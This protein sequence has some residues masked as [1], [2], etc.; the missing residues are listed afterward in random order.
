MI[1]NQLIG[2]CDPDDI[3]GEEAFTV[4]VSWTDALTGIV[5]DATVTL[6]LAD[7]L[8]AEAP[9]LAKGNALVGYAET[10][11]DLHELRYG[12]HGAE[13]TTLCD[14]QSA[15][16]EAAPQD[17][18]I[19]AS[20]LLMASYCNTVRLGE[21]HEGSCDGDPEA[22]FAEALGVCD[23]EV[24]P[25]PKDLG[26][27]S[28][29]VRWG[30]FSRLY[31]SSQIVPREGYRFAALSTG[32][33]GEDLTIP[34]LSGSS[35]FADPQPEYSGEVQ[36]TPSAQRVYDLTTVSITLTAP[37]DAHSFSFDFDFFSAEYP[38]F[39]GSAYN[40]TFYAVIEA[41]STNAGAPTNISF[42]SRGEPIEI[43]NN[44]FDNAYHP[45]TETGTGFVNR[46]ST[47]WLRT[48]W[49]ISP[50]ETFTLTFSIHD[51]GDAIYSSTVL[52]DNF[53]FHTH[54][55]VGMTDPL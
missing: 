5:S 53:R 14:A 50:G 43:N 23:A 4:S 8:A 45:C 48:S 27:G 12:G 18:D 10:L 49:P 15:L 6:T 46:A 35:D 3:T 13:I 32:R 24:F 52:L 11:K 36:I 17:E 21:F 38:N 28:E 26:V 51:E 20:A 19:T 39:I 7:L 40:D 44:Y 33:V 2:T 54:D 42:D 30:A 55:A 22:D 47:C 41:E 34:G 16:F 25:V 31:E 9:N 37:V 29:G 1:F